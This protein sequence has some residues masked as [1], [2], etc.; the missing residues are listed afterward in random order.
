MPLFTQY[1]AQWYPAVIIINPI[2]NYLESNLS[3]NVSHNFMNWWRDEGKSES[4]YCYYI[5][6]ILAPLFLFHM[7]PNSVGRT[8]TMWLLC[9]H[10][11]FTLTEAL[12]SSL[13]HLWGAL[14]PLPY[15][16]YS[17]PDVITG[18]Q[19]ANILF[20]ILANFFFSTFQSPVLL[21]WCH[22]FHNLFCQ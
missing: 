22:L 13:T 2:N 12:Y 17:V 9:F 21:S 19:A 7:Y 18:T 14:L 10:S 3:R 8:I 5:R 20:F 11:I 16:F 6:L 4:N 15:C 1:V